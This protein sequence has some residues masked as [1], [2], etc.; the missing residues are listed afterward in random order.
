VNKEEDIKLENIFFITQG[1]IEA[2]KIGV[3][4]E[5]KDNVYSTFTEAVE[6]ACDKDAYIASKHNWSIYKG[7]FAEEA[8]KDIKLDESDEKHE[9]EEEPANNQCFIKI[10]ANLDKSKLPSGFQ[11][12]KLKPIK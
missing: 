11:R 6:A 1:D 2:A 5:C 9:L 12:L 4:Y 3:P 10:N 7:G 8:E